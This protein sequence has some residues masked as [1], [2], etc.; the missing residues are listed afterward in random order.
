MF[1]AVAKLTLPKPNQCLMIVLSGKCND[2][3]KAAVSVKKE[4]AFPALV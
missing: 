1:P 4:E 3:G 2:T